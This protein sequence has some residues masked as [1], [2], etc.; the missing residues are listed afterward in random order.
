M[1]EA[2]AHLEEAHQECQ[3]G[4][5][6]RETIKKAFAKTCGSEKLAQE[7][8]NSN[9]YQ[10]A[11]R[12]AFIEFCKQNSIEAELVYI[13]FYNGYRSNPKKNLH[14]ESGKWESAMKQDMDCLQLSDEL[15]SRIHIVCIDCLEPR[16]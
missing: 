2:K 5:K 6:S 1:V 8:L 15:K 12:L 7:W 16:K 4:E 13:C 10:L 11:N 9:C 3:A 14:P